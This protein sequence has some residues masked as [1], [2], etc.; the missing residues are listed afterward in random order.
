M[1]G[2]FTTTQREKPTQMNDFTTSPGFKEEHPNTLVIHCSDGRYTKPVFELLR[3]TGCQ[4]YD[5]MA[6][7]GG[8]ALLDMVGASI[9]EAEA[10][11][12]GISF[13]VKS[14]H[15]SIINLIAHADCG[16]YKSRFGG[17]GQQA[18]L[19]KQIEDMQNAAAWLRRINPKLLILAYFASPKNGSVVFQDI[20]IDTTR[21]PL[22]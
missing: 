17:M 7:P 20:E 10:C 15:T 12:T 2:I 8:P 16:Y 6:M 9:T 11:R 1:G 4:R 14:H 13:L 22:Y 3:G 19:R 21:T 5:V 18:L